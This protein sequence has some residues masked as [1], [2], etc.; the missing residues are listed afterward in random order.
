LRESFYAANFQKKIIVS[1]KSS[2]EGFLEKKDQRCIQQTKEKDVII[3]NVFHLN[4]Q[5]GIETF[6]DHLF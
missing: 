2:S 5:P 1:E 6:F 4:D 3:D